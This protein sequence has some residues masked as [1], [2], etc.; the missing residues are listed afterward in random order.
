MA[1]AELVI[2][3]AANLARFQTDLTKV[4]QQGEDLQKTLSGQFG[5]VQGAIDSLGAGFGK[6]TGAVAAITSAVAG[7]AAFKS[8]VSATTQWTGEAVKLSKALGITTEQASI[9]NVALGD[10]YNTADA[11][12]AGNNALTRT[13][14]T[15]EEAFKAVG[16]ATRDQNGN[17]RT[18]MEVMADVNRYL[19]SLRAGLDKNVEGQKLYGKGWA[20]VQG[21]MKLTPEVMKDAADKAQRLHLIVG[22]EGAEQLKKYK[23]V[24]NDLDDVMTS[25]KVSLGNALLPQLVEFGG[26]MAGPLTDAAAKF[27]EGLM[28]VEAELIRMAMLTDKA[29]G[30]VTALGSALAKAAWLSWGGP[31]VGE[32]GPAKMFG[33]VA[34]WFDQ[35]NATFAGRYAQGDKELQRMANLMVGLDENGNPLKKSS[36][37]GG[38]RAAGGAGDAAAASADK[39]RQFEDA[40]NGVARQI[41]DLNPY[42]TETE[43]ENNRINDAITALLG[44]FPDHADQIG[45]IGEAWKK[46]A[47]TLREYNAA[48]ESRKR[49]AELDATYTESLRALDQTA[50]GLGQF[51]YSP[52]GEK[53]SLLGGNFDLLSSTYENAALEKSLE[54]RYKIETRYNDMIM[55]SK[56][57]FFQSSMEL[58]Q[59]STKEGSALF[60]AALLAQRAMAVAQIIMQTNVAAA[61]AL[62]PPPLG[63][64][65]VAGA[66]LAASIEAMGYANAAITGAI[67]LIDVAQSVSGRAYGGP[68]AAGNTYLVGEQ[69]PELIRM[70]ANG[71]V[72]PNHLLPKGGGGVNQTV[73]YQISTGVTDT[74]RAEIM[75]LA[76]ALNAAAVAAVEQ[77]INSGTSL[78]RAVGR[79]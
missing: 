74:V 26:N 22:P 49:A 69:G 17:Y 71:Y 76:P 67:G 46:A 53:P 11:M 2:D 65:P 40:I 29:G 4:K 44:K 73:V 47:A 61:A 15:N 51:R 24:M 27:G 79:M 12:L 34:D 30:S 63:L 18:T 31:L 64:G 42:L 50:S 5:K 43:K 7:G 70:N 41:R 13:M 75:R 25:L 56:M 6:L 14:R 20:E 21:L 23:A 72:T 1:L 38:G 3:F 10:T 45:I 54:E 62:A 66:P 8:V 77:A 78:S 36:A 59:K 19:G 58:I 32:R 55:A 35:Q 68:V 48:A 37:P 9:L 52:Q 39:F 33:N 60:I 28:N 57:Q 16:I